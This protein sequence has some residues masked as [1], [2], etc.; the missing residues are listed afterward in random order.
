MEQFAAYQILVERYTKDLAAYVYAR[1]EY[2]ANEC[3]L[4]E[5]FWDDAFE[6]LGIDRKHPKAPMLRTIAWEN[7]HPTGYSEVWYWLNELVDLIR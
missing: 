3:A 5:M 2:D 1:N 6:N 4:Q 7:G